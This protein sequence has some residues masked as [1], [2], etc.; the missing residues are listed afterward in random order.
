MDL[1]SRW[2]RM[3]REGNAKSETTKSETTKS[4]T[5]PKLR[6]LCKAPPKSRLV[7]RLKSK[8]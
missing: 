2:I 4:E 6:P 8:V 7:E 5:K 3:K 1:L